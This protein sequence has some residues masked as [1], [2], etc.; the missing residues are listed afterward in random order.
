MPVDGLATA[1]FAQLRS[2]HRHH[3]LL[4]LPA[5]SEAMARARSVALAA[6]ADLGGRPRVAIDVDPTDLL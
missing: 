5:G 2:R 3:V 1:P 4:K 6:T